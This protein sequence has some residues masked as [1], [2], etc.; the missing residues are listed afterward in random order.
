MGDGQEQYSCSAERLCEL[1]EQLREYVLNA[2]D[3]PAQVYGLGVILLR[4][5]HAWIKAASQYADVQCPS[6][7]NKLQSIRL[8]P[9]ENAQ[10]QQILADVLI[11]HCHREV[12]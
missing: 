5:M 1:Y 11:Q 2:L 10:L 6:N 12:L 7:N 3:N 9:V 8:Q 4:G